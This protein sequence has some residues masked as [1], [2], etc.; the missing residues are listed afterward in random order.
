VKG[1]RAGFDSFLP[2]YL[3]LVKSWMDTQNDDDIDDSFLINSDEHGEFQINVKFSIKFFR[4]LTSQGQI[5]PSSDDNA[6]DSSASLQ[7]QLGYLNNL[8]DAK[9]LPGPIKF[10][11][12][13][14]KDS[15]VP[16]CVLREVFADGAEI[17]RMTIGRFPEDFTPS[18]NSI[19][20][21]NEDISLTFLGESDGYGV[22]CRLPRNSGDGRA[23]IIEVPLMHQR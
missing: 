13:C 15:F 23:Y 11:T 17:M 18:S 22:M 9:I 8:V 6:R 3:Q 10:N 12:I 14:Q 1:L 19:T 20:S 16:T 5:V 4:S 21:A 2:V 7:S